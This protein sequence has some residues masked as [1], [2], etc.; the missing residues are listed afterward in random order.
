LFINKIEI[1][2]KAQENSYT[3]KLTLDGDY[4]EFIKQGYLRLLLVNNKNEEFNYTKSHKD[5]DKNQDNNA[6]K[7]FTFDL[8]N[9]TWG[10]Q[11][12]IK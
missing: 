2:K 8:N 11:Y 9:L 10:M 12:T 1:N 6:V 3:L 5:T 7:Y 4:S